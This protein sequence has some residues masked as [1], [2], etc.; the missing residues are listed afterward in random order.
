MI[1]P[2]SGFKNYKKLHEKIEKDIVGIQTSN[3]I[4][5]SGQSKHFIERVIGTKE[6][7]KTNRPRSGVEI[8][9]IIE[10]LL[11]GK[12]RENERDPDSIKFITDKCIV[13]VNPNTG[14]L[15]QCNPQ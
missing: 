5:I 2:L 7:P 3:G 4:R 1:S 6:D 14:I 15:I 10:A 11:Y 9:N 13:S 12:L 8:E